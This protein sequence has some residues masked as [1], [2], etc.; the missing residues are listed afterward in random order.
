MNS[1]QAAQVKAALQENSVLGPA[2]IQS[3]A[4]LLAINH[5]DDFHYVLVVLWLLYFQKSAH[6]ASELRAVYAL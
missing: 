5:V 4:D 2:Q 3:T 6:S 1:E